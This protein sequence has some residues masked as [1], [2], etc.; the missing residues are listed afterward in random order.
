MAYFKLTL[1]NLTDNQTGNNVS[2]IPQTIS[3][4]YSQSIEFNSRQKE[5]LNEHKFSYC[6]SYDE[7]IT[8]KQN[9]QKD[10]SFSMN[11]MILKNDEWIENPFVRNIKVG[12]QL[13]L[14]DK[15]EN[16][17]LFTVTEINFDFKPLNITYNFKCQDSFTY[18]LSRQNDGYEIENK[19]SDEDFIG[20]QTVDWWVLNKIQPECRIPYH[21]IPLEFG[22]YQTINNE[23]RIFHVDEKIYDAKKII[24]K[25]FKEPKY[26]EETGEVV[27]ENDIKLFEKI[28][29]SA[30]GSAASVLIE[31]GKYLDLVLNTFE[32]NEIKNNK[33]TSQF[34]RYFWFEPSK[35]EDITGLKYSPYSDIQSFSFSHKGDSLTTVL[36][37][38]GPVYDNEFITLLPDV[39]P[40]FLTLFNSEEW[41][42]SK[43]NEKMY[44]S[45]IYGK[46]EYFKRNRSDNSLILYPSGTDP[47]I[48]INDKSG[49]VTYMPNKERLFIP[50]KNINT[51]YNFSALYEDFQ[52]KNSF[53]DCSYFT[54]SYKD[55][56]LDVHTEIFSN[57]T[58]DN[59]ELVIFESLFKRLYT[60]L[61]TEGK[62]TSL[63]HYTFGANTLF[64]EKPSLIT[65][66][67]LEI[68]TNSSEDYSK[69]NFALYEKDSE[70]DYH[71]WVF[72]AGWVFLE[73]QSD[74][75][76]E[77]KYYET[78]IFNGC[79]LN[80]VPEDID[81]EWD[82]NYQLFYSNPES[83]LLNPIFDEENDRLKV[84]TENY[85]GIENYLKSTKYYSMIE[86]SSEI[87]R[88]WEYKET[89]GKY[90]I[91]EPQEVW[92]EELVTKDNKS[93]WLGKNV[94]RLNIS[95]PLVFDI[96]GVTDWKITS[97]EVFLRF[98]RTPTLE[99][100]EFAKAADE[101]PWLE[102]KLINFNY[103][104]DHNI[105]NK[106]D[107]NKINNI[108]KNN[109]RIVNG[110]LL[111]H[112]KEYY[113]ALHNKTKILADLVNKFDALGAAF[114]YDIISKYSKAGKINDYNYFQNAY[115]ILFNTADIPK[116]NNNTILG[117]DEV[118]TDYVNKYFNSQ[119]RFF[120]NLYNF[121]EYFESPI[122]SFSSNSCLYR[123][124]IELEDNIIEKESED[125][126]SKIVKRISFRD[127]KFNS[128]NNSFLLWSSDS[129]SEDY[130]KPFIPIYNTFNENIISKMKI[131]DK[132]NY[133]NFLRAKDTA[134]SLIKCDSSNKSANYNLKEKYYFKDYII[135]TATTETLNPIPEY[136]L[137]NHGEKWGIIE[138]KNSEGKYLRLRLIKPQGI[139]TADSED[140]LK[141]I[142]N[143]QR[144]ELNPIF[145]PATKNEI[146][147]NYLGLL[148]YRK[149]LLY[150]LIDS[151]STKIDIN[152]LEYFRKDKAID[153][154]NIYQKDYDDIYE[155]VTNWYYN[156]NNFYYWDKE[157]SLK[158]H[159]YDKKLY[160]WLAFKD[161]NID[162][163]TKMKEYVHPNIFKDGVYYKNFPVSTVYIKTRNYIYEEDER[164]KVKVWSLINANKENLVNYLEY[165][166]FGTI[167]GKEATHEVQNPY[168]KNNWSYVGI[169][170]INP[171]TY[172]NFS[173]RSVGNFYNDSNTI[174]DLS[175]YMT[176]EDT[177]STTGYVSA[178]VDNERINQEN[179]DGNVFVWNG[180]SEDNF[181]SNGAMLYT[182]DK[183]SYKSYNYN[184]RKWSEAYCSEKQLKAE[185]YNETF[186]LNFQPVH[187]SGVKI[188][189]EPAEGKN[190]FYLER[191]NQEHYFEM[192]PHKSPYQYY[193]HAAEFYHTFGTLK[194]ALS[195]KPVTNELIYKNPYKP[196]PVSNYC[197]K[198]ENTKGQL[199]TY[200][201]KDKWLVPIKINE[202][203]SS[204]ESYLFIPLTS[205]KASEMTITELKD[206]WNSKKEKPKY[207]KRFIGYD[208]KEKNDKNSYLKDFIKIFST[209]HLTNYQ[210]DTRP[211]ISAIVHYPLLTNSIALS[212][213]NLQKNLKYTAKEMLQQNIVEN[214]RM[215]TTIQDDGY[216]FL[217]KIYRGE[218]IDLLLEEIYG[219]IVRVE[220]YRRIFSM[221]NKWNETFSK[222][223]NRLE[224]K[225][226]YFIEEKEIDFISLPNLTHGFYKELLV[227]S[228]LEETTNEDFDMDAHYYTPNGERVYTIKQLMNLENG[229]IL[230]IKPQFIE[231]STYEEENL[232][233]NK[234]IFEVPIKVTSNS[235]INKGTASE[236]NWVSTGSS[237]VENYNITFIANGDKEQGCEGSFDFEGSTIKYKI[238]GRKLVDIGLLNNG[239]FWYSFH[240]KLNNP[241]LFEMAAAIETQLTQYWSVAYN[242]SHYCEYFL[243]ESWK[244]SIDGKTNYFAKWIWNL[245]LTENEKFSA[246][247]RNDF[248]PN[249]SIL[250][251]KTGKYLPSY[252]ITYKTNVEDY[253][254]KNFIEQNARYEESI[255]SMNL[256]TA[257]T[258]LINNPA[259]VEA[260]NYLG[261]DMSSWIAERIG[262]KTFYHSTS[263]GCLHKD[264]FSKLQLSAPDF[265]FYDGLY[266]M[267]I[268]W[269]KKYYQNRTTKLYD[270]YIKK[271]NNIWYNLYNSYPGILLEGKFQND[272]ATT[273]EELMVLAKNAFKDQSN[274]ERDYQITV[275]DNI[276]DLD[277][278]YGQEIKIGDGIE[279]NVN[280]FYEGFDDIRD[281]LSQYLFITDISY[282][283]RK[284]TDISLTVNTIKYQDKLIQRLVKLIK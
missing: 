108:I 142:I 29:F 112:T 266:V 104:Y 44:S 148:K 277:G 103:F 243:P 32:Q 22:L 240:D 182:K 234:T 210:S 75:D 25:P 58:N 225:D 134:G 159:F 180:A 91:F 81:G 56:N 11:R 106:A 253:F 57:E 237:K 47:Q 140:N 157:N 171:S 281:S 9:G 61:K 117:F 153:V 80:I 10:L 196:M 127:L 31:L 217:L 20:A 63:K 116:Q 259:Y 184:W 35:N 126:N 107:Y 124:T 219:L 207:S 165:V 129:T 143:G 247:L 274:P 79:D 123:D 27:E 111:W 118:L 53:N 169:P 67:R 178:S 119:Q 276:R 49:V 135:D 115:R 175:T 223:Y 14:E 252:K 74:F 8:L 191:D 215:E 194:A 278:Y 193:L 166:S 172:T 36:N 197:G 204:E 48:K 33:R 38:H 90:A 188:L 97:E 271:H 152:A 113:S 145:T 1:L 37:V 43:Y 130:G 167:N 248:I 208:P 62:K 73:K 93:I 28:P 239:E 83:D 17:F 94:E 42:Y 45:I 256:E 64:W 86:N 275:I 254:N 51:G 26:N 205:K 147:K 183:N 24:K 92:K 149:R 155:P 260:F 144:K 125:H 170:F 279:L 168:D 249:I 282:D 232:K 245:H 211:R 160:T 131:A 39:P 177:F 102:N 34:I 214:S 233:E 161:S 55:S 235:Y 250:T 7:K 244:P 238:T 151:S 229:N 236:E 265:S 199:E 84:S 40:F 136:I 13:H 227:D 30:S 221:R 122:T 41:E 269:L 23:L 109:L 272:N 66:D 270:Y 52:F 241:I 222:W 273:S 96:S 120:E 5:D 4:F 101:I 192:I 121:K 212:T 185:K 190:V 65:P 69:Y 176:I 77:G 181:Y 255:N 246:S 71:E 12:T 200:Y 163:Q 46:T 18:Q 85:S 87:I 257:D 139:F 19:S 209:S 82:N 88:L 164:S 213:T 224:I 95:I 59:W 98:F 198:T 179:T 132:T 133:W 267:I 264:I 158:S 174:N 105:I 201:Y 231:S 284:D 230:K 2:Y 228:N 189:N 186:K 68:K 99:D 114:N 146:I 202:I 138:E 154:D 16:E 258:V 128:V 203:V 72:K 15:Y 50:I 242:A 280:E 261:L 173:Y 195:K 268:K 283:L 100:I 226:K 137:D 187:Y 220:D 89:S 218:G 60:D 150:D 216:V 262:L 251:S 70:S 156:S 21:Y 110:R 78:F 141:F 263:G 3:E 54:C 76:E 162:Y 206:D 6:Y